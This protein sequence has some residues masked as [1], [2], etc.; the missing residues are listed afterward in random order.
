ML[1]VGLFLSLGLDAQDY[2]NQVLILNEGYF[3]YVTGTIVEPVKIGTYDPINAT[4]EEVAILEDMRFRSSFQQRGFG[5]NL[6]EEPV[7]L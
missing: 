6:I 4:Y 5:T 7:L 1:I 3:D 2:V